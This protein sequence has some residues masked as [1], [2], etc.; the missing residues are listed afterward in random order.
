MSA[1]QPIMI[2]ITPETVLDV[3]LEYGMPQ[4]MYDSLSAAMDSQ[5]KESLARFT[6]LGLNELNGKVSLEAALYSIMLTLV[7]TSKSNFDN[8]IYASKG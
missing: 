4:G 5:A 7:E 8:G 2:V 1:A 6:I 3:Y